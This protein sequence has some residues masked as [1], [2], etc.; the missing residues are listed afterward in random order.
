MNA[1]RFYK[2]EKNAIK[3]LVHQLKKLV[4]TAL[5]KKFCKFLYQ[6]LQ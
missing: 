6:E 4:I 1:A 2:Q 5:D 3:G